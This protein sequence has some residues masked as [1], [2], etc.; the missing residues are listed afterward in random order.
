MV[1]LSQDHLPPLTGKRSI[2]AARA[3]VPDTSGKRWYNMPAPQITE[4]VKRDLRMIRL[5][6]VVGR[7][8]PVN[9]EWVFHLKLFYASPGNTHA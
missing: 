7:D 3:E 8:L 6:Y 1:H 2:R 9:W 5:R 4:E